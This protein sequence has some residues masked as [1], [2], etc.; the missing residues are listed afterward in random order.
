M[1]KLGDM[2]I[3]TKLTMAFVVLAL[4]TLGTSVLSLVRMSGTNDRV[5]EITDNWLPS[6]RVL[7]NLDAAV[8]EHRMFEIGHMLA[9]TDANI[10]EM[11]DRVRATRAKIAKLRSTYD[12]LITGPEEAALAAEIDRSWA[13]YLEMSD[14]MLVLSRQNRDEDA[15]QIQVQEGRGRNQAVRAALDKA[16]AFNDHGAAAGRDDAIA[17]YQSSRMTVLIASGVA[18][19]LSIAFSLLARRGIGTPIADMTTAMTHLAE[20][21]KGTAIPGRGRG[22][23]IGAMA[24]AVQVFKENMIRADQLAAEQQAA[25]AERERRAQAIETMTREFDEAVTGVLSIVS[26]ASTEMEATA[27]AVTTTAQ[28][29]NQRA[30]SVAAA[31]EQTTASLQ[32]VAS[33]AEE[34]SNSIIEIGQQVDRSSRASITASEEADSTQ[35]TVRGLAESSARIGE[36]VG[37]INDIASQTNLLALNAT[38][39]A[40]RA[41]EA[42]KGFAVVAGEVK[43]LAN[44]TARATEEIAQQIGAVQGATQQAVTAISAIVTRIGEIRDISTSIA[45]AVE[46]QSAATSEIA[47]NIQQ[48]AGGAQEV[49]GTIGEVSQAAAETG[50]AAGQVLSSARTLSHEADTLR[51]TVESFLR[52]VREA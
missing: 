47:R 12:G 20:G 40:A 50:T 23:E 49:S 22:D 44:Q 1:R 41:G 43:N 25:Q 48:A 51:G 42:G 4:L 27:Q 10:A 3:P 46:E 19:A 26:G 28:E 5:M 16:I 52:N 8:M 35:A 21:N 34:L 7:A 13:S 6:V 2:K 29:T 39:E 45:A 18:L 24:S 9:A 33:A 15:R 38:I 11:D 17:S 14:R 30:T 36:V 32:T 37:L 31:T